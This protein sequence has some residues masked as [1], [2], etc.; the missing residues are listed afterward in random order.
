MLLIE[1]LRAR[2]F[3]F[4]TFEQCS[5][6]LIVIFIYSCF[7]DELLL[8]DGPDETSLTA[9]LSKAMHLGSADSS[10]GIGRFNRASS[11][12]SNLP[13][14]RWNCVFSRL[15][16]L[17]LFLSKIKHGSCEFLCI[18]F[19]LA[20]MGLFYLTEHM[21]HEMTQMTWG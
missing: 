17:S 3:R 9:E 11:T 18:Y 4:L 7:S 6:T 12:S 16:L 8:Q 5:V 21:Q 10:V 15:D 14:Q 2:L 13:I 19:L 1:E 20:I